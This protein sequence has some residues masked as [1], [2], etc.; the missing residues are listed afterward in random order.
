LVHVAR[1]ASVFA[2][3][4]GRG[5][6][7]LCQCGIYSGDICERLGPQSA[8]VQ[9]SSTRLLSF[10]K[11]TM[12]ADTLPVRPFSNLR[13][14][15]PLDHNET[16]VS[17]VSTMAPQE[18]NKIIAIGFAFFA[19]IFALTFV[20][21]ML[22]SVGVFVALGL[23]MASETGDNTNAGIGIAGGVVSII[24]YCVL[25]LF[26]VVPPAVASRKAFKRRRNTRVWGTI[27]AIVAFSLFSLGTLLG[28]YALWFFYGAVGKD[29][30][31]RG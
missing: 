19:A 2:S 20:L 10:P 31:T 18:H 24:F 25:G 12:R 9:Y 4:D 23:T 22:V 14:L 27:A 16:I 15:L 3:L 7:D 13:I 26:F 6:A 17:R 8:A 11:E 28:A 29:F 21:L 5:R 30:Y 1:A